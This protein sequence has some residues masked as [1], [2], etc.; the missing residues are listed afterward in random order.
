MT[1]SARL[2]A[3]IEALGAISSEAAPPADRVLDRY[4]RDRRYIGSK[5]RA[6]IAERVFG[7]LRRRAR[8]DWHLRESGYRDVL[9]ARRRVLADVIVADG[10]SIDAIDQLFAAGPHATGKLSERERALAER[11]A[12]RSLDAPDAPPEAPHWLAEKLRDLYGERFAEE[13]SVLNRTAPFDLRVNRL[14][15]TREDALAA[16]KS[17]GI[18]A[19]PTQLSPLGLRLPA[20]KPIEHWTAF[21]SGLVEVQDEGSQI[22]ALLVDAKPGMKLVD[23][24]AGAGGKTLA[25]AAAMNNEG[26][27]VACDTSEGRLDRSRVRLRRAGVHNV[28]THLLTSGDKWVKRQAASFDRVLVDAPCSGS[29]TWRRNPDAR[30]RYGPDDLKSLIEDQKQILDRAAKLVKPGGRLVYATCALLREENEDQ[31]ASFLERN[32]GFVQV[33][34]PELWPQAVGGE[35]PGKEP[36]LRLSPAQ[37]GTDGFFVAV[38][39]RRA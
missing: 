26:R 17:E 39:E 36:A 23:F 11:L 13:M 37:H 9:D 31:V 32:P 25:L 24:C 3:A 4:F 27:I 38:L 2:A 1:P 21:R 8:L 12:G 16:L 20:R 14:K 7:V 10:R 5:D 35:A 29:G 18:E 22:V 30:W 15:G 6:A 28:E 19:E 33:P 34:V